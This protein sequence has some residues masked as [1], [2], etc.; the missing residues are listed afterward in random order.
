MTTLRLHNFIKISNYADEDFVNTMPDTRLNNIDSEY[1]LVDTEELDATHGEQ[2]TQIRDNIANMLWK[3][4][5]CRECF[6]CILLNF[7]FIY[8]S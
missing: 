1:A 5:N 6:Y 2:M 4:Q 7:Y 3:N 8:V